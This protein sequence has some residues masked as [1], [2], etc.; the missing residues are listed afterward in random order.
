MTNGSI[1]YSREW[2]ITDKIHIVIP[3]VGDIIDNEDTYYTLVSMLTAMPIDYMVQLDDIGI[4]FT[5]INDYELFMIL[6]P[7]IQALDTSL[8]FGDLDL[9]KFERAVHI[10]T[11]QQVLYDEEND[12]V[13]DR[14]VHTKIADALRKL[15]HL[16]KDERKPGNDEARK[17]M[18]ERARKKMRRK[19]KR[20]QESQLEQLIVA[21]VNTE[22]FKYGYEGTRELTIYQFNES[23]RQIQHKVDYDNRMHGIYAGTVDPKKIS[24]DE[25]NWLIHK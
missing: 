3:T 12:I 9:S 19:K 5:G 11:Q 7:A 20:R 14:V 10:D 2:P 18:L 24:Q 4:D 1:L 13:I 17:Y 16:E 21:M 22:Q 6:F 25:L 8:V 23:V 15:H